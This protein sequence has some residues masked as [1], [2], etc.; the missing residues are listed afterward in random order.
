M[1]VIPEDAPIALGGS[2]NFNVSNSGKI[3][4]WAPLPSKIAS[5]AQKFPEF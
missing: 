3:L 2:W 5:L 4:L 1:I